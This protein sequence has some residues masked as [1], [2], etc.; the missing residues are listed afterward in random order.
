MIAVDA[1]QRLWVGAR[2]DDGD[3]QDVQAEG[4]GGRR[5]Q[6]QDRALAL[7]TEQLDHDH[8]DAEQETESVPA[9]A[10]I[11]HVERVG[12]VSEDHA[13]LREVPA[14]QRQQLGGAASR[15]QLE[16]PDRLVCD[17]SWHADRER[18]QQDR[19]RYPA[20]SVAAALPGSQR[21][22]L[23][24]QR[25]P[26]QCGRVRAEH[27]AQGQQ[28]RHGQSVDVAAT[29]SNIVM[30]QAPEGAP[31]DLLDRLLAAL[32]EAGVRAS[33]AGSDRLRFVLHRDLPSD[34]VSRCLDACRRF[35]AG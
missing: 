7:D 27:A 21:G 31:G 14:D 18:D 8:R 30:L 33:R 25:R 23:E 1:G 5:E 35:D 11:D 32:T 16:P 19:Q 9:A 12:L 17:R 4:H 22:E 24:S 28:A 20:Q 15:G 26:G 29:D 2:G 3:P 13:A 6:Q 34:A 10:G